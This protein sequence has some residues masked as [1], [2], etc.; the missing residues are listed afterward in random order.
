VALRL[1]RA[2]Y[3]SGDPERVLKAP[4]DIVL[5]ALHFEAF[6]HEYERTYYALNTERS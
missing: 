6:K 5:A 3:Y 1:A 4:V 2:G